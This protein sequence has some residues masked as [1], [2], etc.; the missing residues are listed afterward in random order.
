MCFMGKFSHKIEYSPN[1]VNLSTTVHSITLQN[2]EL[3][4][5]VLL[6]HTDDAV[7]LSAVAVGWRHAIGWFQ[8][9][10][11]LDYITSGWK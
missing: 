4:C 7:L 2:I 11:E 6:T 3:N 10:D 5:F 8:T 9:W 1:W